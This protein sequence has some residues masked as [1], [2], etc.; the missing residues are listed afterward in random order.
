MKPRDVRERGL[1]V[2]RKIVWVDITPTAKLYTVEKEVFLARTQ[3]GKPVL[4]KIVPNAAPTMEL[5]F[6]GFVRKNPGSLMINIEI[7]KGGYIS[8]TIAS[9]IVGISSATVLVGLSLGNYRARIYMEVPP[10][11]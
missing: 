3:Q 2:D 7:E 5:R 10:T 1:Y 9:M 6:T 11:T 8:E 4:F